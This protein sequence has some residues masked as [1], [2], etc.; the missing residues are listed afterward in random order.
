M[1]LHSLEAANIEVG[2]GDVS[3]TVNKYS[4][5]IKIGSGNGTINFPVIPIA[6]VNLE[7]LIGSGNAKV[8]IPSSAKV[9]YEI[10]SRNN[11]NISSDDPDPLKTNF[12][13]RMNIGAGRA[14]V[15]NI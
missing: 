4:S 6:Q 10:K 5:S 9:D 2:A 11:Y 12:K 8:I 14:E 15:D 7:I 3:L 1:R 13:I